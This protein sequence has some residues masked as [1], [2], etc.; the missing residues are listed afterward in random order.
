MRNSTCT[1][2]RELVD[3]QIPAIEASIERNRHYLKIISGHY[4]GVD[5]AANDFYSKHLLPY[6]GRIFKALFCTYKCPK[7]NSC[8]LEK[9]NQA[10]AKSFKSEVKE[11]GIDK[12]LEGGNETERIFTRYREMTEGH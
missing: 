8:R 5:E 4:I 12:I 6:W 7:Q 10:I 9:G 11:L 3:T 2:L 1:H